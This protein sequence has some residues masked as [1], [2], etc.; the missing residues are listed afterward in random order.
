MVENLACVKELMCS[1]TGTA[2]KIKTNLIKWA[3]YCS[4]INYILKNNYMLFHVY[5]YMDNFEY[6]HL[7][8]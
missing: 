2:N 4:E 3:N 7:G 1:N 5:K 8:F 6:F